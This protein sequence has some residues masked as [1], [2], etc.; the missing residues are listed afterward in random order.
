MVCLGAL[1][2]SAASTAEIDKWCMAQAKDLELREEVRHVS[3]LGDV[4]FQAPLYNVL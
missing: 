3:E 2:K 4:L 1:A